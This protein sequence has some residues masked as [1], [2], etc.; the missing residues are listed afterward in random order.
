MEADGL[1]LA[2]ASEP[3]TE[4]EPALVHVLASVLAPVPALVVPEHA[5]PERVA[6]LALEPVLGSAPAP[7]PG[8]VPELGRNGPFVPFVPF[9]PPARHVPVLVPVLVHL[10]ELELELVLEPEPALELVRYDNARL[11][12]LSE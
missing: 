6:A 5:V 12:C 4:L 9:A 3:A 7:A 10:L 1:E 11:A 2:L 8:F